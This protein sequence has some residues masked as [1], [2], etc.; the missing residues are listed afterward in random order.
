MERLN[1]ES[2][3]MDKQNNQREIQYTKLY[4]EVPSSFNKFVALFYIIVNFKLKKKNYWNFYLQEKYVFN[5]V[6]FYII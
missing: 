3:R 5:K 4:D 1:N 6:Y 2:E